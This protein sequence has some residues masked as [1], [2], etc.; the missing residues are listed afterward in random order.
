MDSFKN[1]YHVLRV[2]STADDA[3]IK[4]AFRRLARRHHPDVAKNKRGAR[5]F[6]EIREAY[7]VLSNPE[8]RRQYDD[9]YRARRAALRPVEPRV[10]RREMSA[11]GGARS[12]RFGITLD[13]LGLRLGLAVEAEPIR[14]D[15]RRQKGPRR[16]ER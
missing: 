15:V 2:D 9:V 7:H 10:E 5:R 3:T 16:R 6:R 4:A 8:K 11:R 13:V 12:S 1:Y 14:R